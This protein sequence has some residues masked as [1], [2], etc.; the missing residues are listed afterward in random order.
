MHIEECQ[1]D[2]P[3]LDHL[4]C[5]HPVACQTG[6]KALARQS[7]SKRRAKRIVVIGDQQLM[8]SPLHGTTIG[9]TI[10]AL[11][12]LFRPCRIIAYSPLRIKPG[13]PRLVL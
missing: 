8:V 11:A 6:A 1:V 7:I 4:Q 10:G 13:F 9:F 12:G 3:M 5:L 2:T